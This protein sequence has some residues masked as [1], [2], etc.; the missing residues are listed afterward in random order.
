MLENILINETQYTPHIELNYETKVVVL[1]GK[2][3]PENTFEFYAPLLE[4]INKYT[5]NAENEKL[6]IK[7]EI[8]YFNS[9]SSKLFFDL[10][11]ILYESSKTMQINIEWICDEENE[12]AIEAGE[13][14]K[15]DFEDLDFSIKIK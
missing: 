6:D 13:D 12:C 11:D 7:M 10:F 14:F 5:Q 8:I 9:S 2:S 4:W 1:R 3:Y 15:E